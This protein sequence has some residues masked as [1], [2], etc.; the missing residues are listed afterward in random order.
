[1]RGA[2]VASSGDDPFGLMGGHPAILQLFRHIA[3]GRP[4]VERAQEE[5]K[6]LDFPCKSHADCD[7]E[8]K[9]EYCH[10]LSLRVSKGEI[11]TDEKEGRD[12]GRSILAG[13]LYEG[14]DSSHEEHGAEM[15]AKDAPHSCREKREIR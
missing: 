14:D 11:E 10:D 3:L 13:K 9:S 12:L 8:G 2:G 6:S 15:I 4:Q 5:V 7:P 1:M